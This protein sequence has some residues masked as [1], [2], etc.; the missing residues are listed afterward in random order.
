[1]PKKRPN[2]QAA[3]N[4]LVI[5]LLGARLEDGVLRMVTED[6]TKRW[7][8]ATRRFGRIFYRNRNRAQVHTYLT[9]HRMVPPGMTRV[10]ALTAFVEELGLLVGYPIDHIVLPINHLY[11]GSPVHL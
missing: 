7:Q 2:R 11:E 1:M 6:S 8:L 3:A 5:A 10:D 9:L 4:E